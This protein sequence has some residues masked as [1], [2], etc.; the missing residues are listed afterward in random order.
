MSYLQ[1]IYSPPPP[2]H[3][4]N[5]KTTAITSTIEEDNITPP[6]RR[7]PSVASI[8]SV[9]PPSSAVTPLS[10]RTFGTWNYAVG[11]A[12]II[13]AYHMNERSWY[14]MSLYTNV[15]G[16]IHFCSEAFVYKTAKPQG[17]WLVP[18]SVATVGLVWH[19]LQMDHYIKA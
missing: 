6:D 12:R 9:E 18:V 11:V 17:P 19:F 7:R 2:S 16:L 10:A 15:I 5:L 14:M 3:S 8:V 13:A 4:L 1:R